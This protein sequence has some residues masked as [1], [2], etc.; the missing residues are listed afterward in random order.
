MVRR[1]IGWKRSVTSSIRI[2]QGKTVPNA[3]FKIS[4]YAESQRRKNGNSFKIEVL[5]H[6]IVGSLNHA[7]L[8][9]LGHTTQLLHSP[10]LDFRFSGV[11]SR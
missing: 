4:Y 10:G 3:A 9:S 2:E 5:D 8:R 7:S 1:L 6:I 11:S